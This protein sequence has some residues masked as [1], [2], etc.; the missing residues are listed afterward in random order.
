MS[1]YL[2]APRDGLDM[3][4]SEVKSR[5]ERR[6]YRF[7]VV[8]ALVAA[9][10]LVYGVL[11]LGL[12]GEEGD[13]FDRMYAGVLGIG[14]L[15]ALIGR[16]RAGGMARAMF[17][18]ALAQALITVIALA[19]GKHQSPVTSIPE[20]VGLNGFFIVLFIGSALLFRHAA[21]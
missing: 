13:P 15:G 4:L 3:I 18:T 12:I 8:V 9:L 14:I 17:A 1:A 11:A 6:P 21:R 2:S 7:G 10:I 16:F 19:S 5:I 20:L